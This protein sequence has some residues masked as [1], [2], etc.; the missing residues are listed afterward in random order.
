MPPFHREIAENLINNIS[1]QL[2]SITNMP[3]IEDEVDYDLDKKY[4]M[5]DAFSFDLKEKIYNPRVLKLIT[6]VKFNHAKR[7]DYFVMVNVLN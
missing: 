4:C 3:L 6:K 5:K 2:K 7:V 1:P